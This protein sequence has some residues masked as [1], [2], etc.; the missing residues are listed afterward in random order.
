MRIFLFFFLFS[1]SAFADSY[2]VITLYIYG[3]QSYSSLG[4]VCSLPNLPN[5]NIVYYVPTNQ[6]C[7]SFWLS[8]GSHANGYAFSPAI[9]NTCPG[10]G[11]LSDSMCLGASAC[12]APQVR[13]TTTG[14]CADPVQTLCQGDEN[15]LD[16][17]CH[18]PLSGEPIA[19]HNGTTVFTPEVCDSAWYEQYIT[20]DPGTS[21]TCIDGRVTSPGES[22]Y[23]RYLD[24]LLNN[25]PKALDTIKFIGFGTGTLPTLGTIA[26]IIAKTASQELVA[27]FPAASFRPLTPGTVSPAP[28]IPGSLATTSPFQSHFNV[29]SEVPK[30][31]LGLALEKFIKANPVSDYVDDF[32][33]STNLAG[34]P[35]TVNP[36]TGV[37]KPQASPVP[38]SSNQLADFAL[39][40]DLGFPQS[41]YHP[42]AIPPAPLPLAQLSPYLHPDQFPWM[43]PGMRAVETDF[44]LV[45]SPG[46]A[47]SPA[48]NFSKISSPSIYVQP[49]P[50]LS[51]LPITR[52]SPSPQ[53]TYNQR[54]PTTT[55]LP[56]PTTNQNPLSTDAQAPPSTPPPPDV[57][58]NPGDSFL[59]PVPPTVY[60]DTYK[61]F[62]FL[63]TANPFFFD[64]SQFMPQLPITSCSYEI[65]E[66]FNVPFLGVKHF[67]VAP[68]VPLEPLRQVLQWAF[69]V[70]TA[71]S[72]FFI[73]T[74]ATFR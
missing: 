54:Q 10:G 29:E 43:G 24:E 47:S 2:P 20:P 60:P 1:T 22:C 49:F 67:D 14:L 40:I 18:Y 41:V 70:L 69:A 26:P 53:P 52:F 16:V 9:T 66:T 51:T 58:I 71:I 57:P 48:I 55:T 15:P 13:S 33:E 25:D 4:S 28:Q 19:C 64:V 21:I 56:A 27:T 73:M 6:Y 36:L 38:L 8:D 30:Y 31:S 45:F 59:P 35:V 23:S 65:H 7:D 74:R 63:P 62:D 32:M 34:F 17:N 3:G 50:S 68:C 5:S 42:I 44:Q 37:V 39:K 11:T 12:V 61:Y 46:V 72:C